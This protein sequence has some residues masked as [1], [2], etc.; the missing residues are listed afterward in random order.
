[1]TNDEIVLGL[2]LYQIID[3]HR[4]AGEV[5]ISA[6][7]SG[8]KSCPHCHSEH[9]RS[10]GWYQRVVRHENLGLRHSRLEVAARKWLCLHCGRQFRQRLPGIL[11]GQHATEPFRE[12]IYRQHLDG[13]N[14]S[15][16]GR[17][18]S[19]GALPSSATSVMD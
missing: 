16:L 6:R 8:P 7:Y 9:Q 14:R 3:I 2:P 4:T 18:E 13:I 10:K 19:I 15:R 12:A 5:R 17:R 1:L 11:P